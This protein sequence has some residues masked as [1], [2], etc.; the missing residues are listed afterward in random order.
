MQ[1][2]IV[3]KNALFYF[4][5]TTFRLFIFLKKK[6]KTKFVLL[7]TKILI[8]FVYQKKLSATL[9]NQIIFNIKIPKIQDFRW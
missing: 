9:Y 3:F 4:E 8:Q 5:L 1:D 6:K 2:K 7:T